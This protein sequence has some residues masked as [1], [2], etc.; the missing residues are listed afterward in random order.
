MVGIAETFLKKSILSVLFADT[1]HG[2]PAMR[3]CDLSG[4]GDLR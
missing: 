3:W 1:S 2:A 4:G